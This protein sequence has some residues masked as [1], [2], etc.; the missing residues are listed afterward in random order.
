MR[1]LSLGT[2]NAFNKLPLSTPGQQWRDRT[3]KCLQ[4]QL[5]LNEQNF[6]TCDAVKQIAFNSHVSCYT[7]PSS[8]ICDLALNDMKSIARVVDIKEYHD[9]DGLKQVVNVGAVCLT[10]WLNELKTAERQKES[11]QQFMTVQYNI[12]ATQAD[13]SRDPAYLSRYLENADNHIK[14]LKLKIDTFSKQ[15]N[16]NMNYR[17]EDNNEIS[18]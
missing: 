6:N 8:S 13:R 5:I 12:A 10:Q 11:A 1:F 2:S 9:I 15:E 14:E 4:D 7:N 18:F 16:V 17:I 3:L